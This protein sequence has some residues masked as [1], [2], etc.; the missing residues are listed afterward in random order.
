MIV[1]IDKIDNCNNNDVA[2]TNA[3]D[4][5]NY[6]NGDVMLIIMVMIIL[7]GIVEYWK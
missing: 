5:N 2:V 1:V 3:D 7:T 6:D 4:V